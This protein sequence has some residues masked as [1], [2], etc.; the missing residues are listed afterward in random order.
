MLLY[1]KET[2]SVVR[3]EPDSEL[4]ERGFVLIGQCDGDGNITGPAPMVVEK[5]VEKEP[6]VKKPGRPKKE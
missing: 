2:L 4:I 6:E 1:R 5:T 3:K